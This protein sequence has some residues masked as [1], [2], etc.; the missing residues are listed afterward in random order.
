MGEVDDEG[1]VASDSPLAVE[2][3]SPAGDVFHVQ[4]VPV[5]GSAGPPLLGTEHGPATRGVL[6]LVNRLL[7]RASWSREER[8]FRALV[9]RGDTGGPIVAESD[10]ASMRQARAAAL[11]FARTIENG[12]FFDA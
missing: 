9:Y 12:S 1:H 10:H 7:A 3:R 6:G 11:A 4:A 5:F 8:A 2:A